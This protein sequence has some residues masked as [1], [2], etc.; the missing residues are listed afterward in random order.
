MRRARRIRSRSRH[1]DA[2]L[3]RRA[4]WTVALQ[5]A[6]AVAL[7]VLVVSAGSVL[8]FDRQQAQ[9]VKDVLQHAATSADDV[10]DPPVGVWLVQIQPPQ[11]NAPTQRAVSAGT[12][13]EVAQAPVLDSAPPG[14]VTIAANGQQW[15]AWVEL[16][17]SSRFVAIYG[18]SRHTSEE[19]RLVVAIATAGL[20]GIALAALIG[21]VVGQRA[22]RPLGDA[23]ARQRRFVADASHELRTPLAVVNTRAQLLA[24]QDSG[25]DPQRSSELAQLVADTRV[26]GDVVTDLLT[27]AQLQH[28][29]PLGEEIDVVALC[30]GVIASMTPYA[31]QH[32]V[33]L[34]F[35]V[36]GASP[37]W[38]YLVR[39]APTALRRAVSA[40]VDNAIAHSP[41]A[42][43]V[44][45]TVRRDDQDVC[46][47]VRDNG[48]GLAPSAAAQLTERFARGSSTG[49]GRRFGLGLALVDEV[50]RAHWGRLDINGNLAP[51]SR[52]TLVLPATG[53]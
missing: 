12:P 23:L 47:H 18:W 51:G 27:S 15:S 14:P 50:V 48:D 2:Q 35:Q 11:G 4:A 1:G 3:L 41:V 20:V 32:D 38:A 9:E 6:L 30:E 43:T 39:G 21:L 34:Q 44:T 17:A 26:L 42:E 8:L 5:I 53:L 46:V 37:R 36:L 25:A 29:S 16:R 45:V 33:R 24:L 13:Q 10:T 52:F 28:H 49:D 31:N 7:V 40:L 19:H 22:V